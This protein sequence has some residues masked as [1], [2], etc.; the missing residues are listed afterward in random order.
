MI[1]QAARRGRLIGSPEAGFDFTSLGTI[2]AWYAA[3]L[4][5]GFVDTDVPASLTD[6]SGNGRDASQGT[7]G[8]RCRF[9]TGIQ[10][11]LPGFNW[12]LHDTWYDLV[13]SF[14]TGS[15]LAVVNSSEN[16]Y[17]DFNGIWTENGGSNLDFIL[18]NSGT[19]VLRNAGAFSTNLYVDQVKT[20]ETAPVGTTKTV[21]GF[22]AGTPA[23]VP[24]YSLGRDGAAASRSWVGYIFEVIVYETKLTEAQVQEGQAALQSIY[25]IS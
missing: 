16:P 23:A 5:T 3:R 7:A 8:N 15:V 18:V 24:A 2:A 17:G 12:G 19:T 4:E 25:G 20:T 9:D 10:N 21:G 13:S 11:G 14:A 6:F 1:L 22:H